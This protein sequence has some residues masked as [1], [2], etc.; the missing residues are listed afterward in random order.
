MS[1]EAI[2]FMIFYS[3]IAFLM[4]L[5]ELVV[6]GILTKDKMFLVRPKFLYEHSNMNM[7]GCYLVTALC[8]VINPFGGIFRLIHFICTVGRKKDV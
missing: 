6:M 3:I 1:E 4:S 8:C 7:F 5:C 2:L